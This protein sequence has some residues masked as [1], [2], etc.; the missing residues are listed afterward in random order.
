MIYGLAV[1]TGLDVIVDAYVAWVFVARRLYISDVVY[2]YIRFMSLPA[3]ALC[4]S[5]RR[6]IVLRFCG[7]GAAG[8]S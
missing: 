4:L 5:W 2:I 1:C 3:N 8:A 6:R 7:G